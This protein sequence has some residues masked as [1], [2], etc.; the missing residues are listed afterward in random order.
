MRKREENK[1]LN[2]EKIKDAIKLYD[3][4]KESTDEDFKKLTNLLTFQAYPK[5]LLITSEDGDWNSIDTPDNG[6]DHYYWGTHCIDIYD[7]KDLLEYLGVPVELAIL[8]HDED[9]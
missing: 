4:T 2:V 7:V 5:I 6:F 1:M 9:F 3:I 8:R